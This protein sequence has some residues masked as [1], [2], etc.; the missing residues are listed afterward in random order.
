QL[1]PGDLA[2][3]GLR[4]GDLVHLTSRRGSIVVPAQGARELS[5]GLAWM[6][7]HWGSEMLSGRGNDGRP[8]AGVNALTLPVYCPDSRQPELKGA[9]VRILKAE[10]PWSLLAMAWVPGQRAVAVRA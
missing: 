9:A 1:H 7:M 3:L 6:P 8:M 4:D 2:R 10:L 5:P